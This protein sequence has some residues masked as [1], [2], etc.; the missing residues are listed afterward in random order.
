MQRAVMISANADMARFFELEL[1]LCG[2]ALDVVRSA[3]EISREYSAIIFDLD[4]AEG[5]IPENY[6]GKVIKISERES[7]EGVLTWPVSIEEIHSACIG[8][9][10]HS[11]N[12]PNTAVNTQIIR[13]AD[14]ENGEVSMGNKHIR[15]TKSEFNIL[16]ALCGA[17]GQTVPREKIME[18]LGAEN[19]NISDVY[20]CRLR[21]K[22]EVSEGKRLIFTERGKGYRTTLKML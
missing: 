19:G 7:T 15:L 10:S 16:E 21:Q 17:N 5:S 4:T 8:D 9:A 14:R 12:L 13:I 1:E 6:K 18:I 11:S 20:V 2:Y 3:S 22:L